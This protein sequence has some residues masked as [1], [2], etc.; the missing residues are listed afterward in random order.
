MKVAATLCSAAI[1]SSPATASVRTSKPHDELRDHFGLEVISLKIVDPRFYHLDTSLAVLSDDTVAFYP[2]AIDEDSQKR[3]R[4]AI[5]NLI[6]ATEEEAK[7]FGLN[8]ISDGHT[9]IQQ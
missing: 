6:E 3:L 5:P 2:G 8:A 1:K 7:G 9:V 4:A